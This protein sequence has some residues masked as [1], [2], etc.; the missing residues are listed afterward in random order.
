MSKK[1]EPPFTTA[2]AFVE[3]IAETVYF[4]REGQPEDR[5]PIFLH[6]EPSP[7][8]NCR[9]VLI[10]GDNASGKSFLA[11]LMKQAVNQFWDWESMGISMAHRMK[12]YMASLFYGDE[13][14]HSTGVNSLRMVNNALKNL[15]DRHESKRLN[16]MSWDE[17]DIGLAESY[18]WAMGDM[19]AKTYREMPESTRVMM[20]VTHSKPIAH[21]LSWLKPI[22]VRVGDTT[23]LQEFITRDEP[24]LLWEDIER[25]NER[26][27]ALHSAISKVENQKKD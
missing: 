20:V 16:M 8:P 2:L 5:G 21:V 25:L 10:T 23:S 15:V 19:I 14:R 27:H 17:P 6:I 4:R 11:R 1:P 18:Q 26:A 3:R 7:D 22:H 24:M 12:G 9:L 13:S